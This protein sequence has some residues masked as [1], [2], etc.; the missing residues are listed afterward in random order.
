[1][2]EKLSERKIAGI[3]A[4]VGALYL[5][6]VGE[7]ALGSVIL[8]SLVSFFVGERNGERRTN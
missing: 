3:F 5:I 4:G 8:S 1:M 2:I 6:F 7:V